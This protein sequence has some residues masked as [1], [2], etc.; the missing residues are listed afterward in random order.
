MIPS[1]NPSIVTLNTYILCAHT[2]EV[3]KRQTMGKKP[4]LEWIDP[5]EICGKTM[6]EGV[7]T[8]IFPDV[9]GAIRRMA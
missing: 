4:G 5:P 9:R 2:S 1:S 3:I 7:L 6:S 8:S